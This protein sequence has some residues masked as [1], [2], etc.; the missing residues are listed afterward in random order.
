[1][2]TEEQIENRAKSMEEQGDSPLFVG[3]W[4]E[5]ANW[6]LKEAK[7]AELEAENQS[8]REALDLASAFIEARIKADIK[9]IGISVKIEK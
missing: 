8:L 9:D 4:Q 5:G 1:M 7:V 3:G 2:I 6:A